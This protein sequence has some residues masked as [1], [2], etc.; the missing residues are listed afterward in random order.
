VQD[1]LS[2]GYNVGMVPAV[3]LDRDGV[4]IRNRDEYVR[5]WEDVTLYPEA[6]D[7]LSRAGGYP[8][9]FVIV[10]NQSGI[11]R[12]LMS[13]EAVAG[14]NARIVR[15]IEH[16]GGRIDGV[17]VCPH[18]PEDGCSCRKPKPGLLLEAA[19]SLDLDL[20]RSVLIGDAL[21]DIQAGRAAGVGRSWILLAGRGEAQLR[22]PEAAELLPIPTFGNLALA[23]DSLVVGSEDADP[24][25]PRGHG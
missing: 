12:G 13:M 11:G 17:F 3:F 6:I 22:L 16:K 8:Y 7:A 10:T 20:P 14:I 9:R 2:D 21:S 4:L 1:S 24:V 23:L 19:A 18:T 15:E 5:T 25:D